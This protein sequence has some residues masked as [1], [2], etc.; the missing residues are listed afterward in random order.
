MDFKLKLPLEWELPRMIET[1]QKKKN[2]RNKQ[3]SLHIKVPSF[4][5]TLKHM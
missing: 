1:C 4:V 3:A 5:Y 2:S